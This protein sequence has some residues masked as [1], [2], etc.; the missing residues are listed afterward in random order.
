MKIYSFIV[1][2]KVHI[3]LFF[4]FWIIL[5]FFTVMYCCF[6][7]LTHRR[8]KAYFIWMFCSVTSKKQ[9]PQNCLSF[10][11]LKRVDCLSCHHFII[12]RGSEFIISSFHHDLL[13]FYHFI[14]CRGSMF[15]S[16]YYFIIC[17]GSSYSEPRFS[18]TR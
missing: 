13:S 5:L 3:I 11:H 8:V 15:L 12:C 1:F 18:V 17:R 7:I 2:R 10:Y 9:Y 14:I 16:F 4:E 6:P